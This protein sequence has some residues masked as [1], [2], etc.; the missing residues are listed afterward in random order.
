V[1]AAGGS[2]VVEMNYTGTQ[3][4]GSRSIRVDVDPNNFIAEG[5][6][7]DN[8]ATLTLVINAPA[9][10]NLV[11]LASN[12]TFSPL[13]VS[14]NGTV[15]IHA[16]ILN[17]GAR[18]AKDV[19]VQFMDVSG[20]SQKPIGAPQSLPRIG[21]GDAATAQMS[22]TPPTPGDYTLQVVADPNN[23]IVESNEMDN[24]ASKTLTA[25]ASVA[26]NLVA[27]GS[28]L[29]FVPSAPQDGNL[30]TIHATAINNGTAA[31]TDVVVRVEDVTDPAAPVLIG[32][33]RLIDTLAPGEKATVQ[34]IYDTTGKAGE[35]TIRLTLDPIDQIAESD[36]TDNQAETTLTIA[37][38]P[39]PNLVVTADHV[40][41]TPMAPSDGQVV[42]ITVTVLNQGQL[43]ANRVEVRVLDVTGNMTVPVGTL[44]VING[45]TAGGA[46]IVQ[47][48]YDTTGK[49]GD[50]TIRV[51]VDPSNLVPETS[52]TDN[53]VD[54]P[55]TVAPP[56]TN[57]GVL[58][59]LTITNTDVTIS[60]TMPSAGDVVTLTIHVHNDGAADASSVMVRVMDVTE[61]PVQVGDDVTIPAIV[62][63]SSMTATILY[64]TTGKSGSRMLT[65]SADPNNTITE[66]NENDN[67]ATTTIPL[68]SGGTASLPP[69]QSQ[70]GSLR[71]G[72][73]DPHQPPSTDV[74]IQVATGLDPRK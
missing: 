16:I 18:E 37:P 23:F 63:G 39:S 58:P 59:N 6:E 15:N 69:A 3:K 17:Q 66:S 68:G 43:N 46:G 61:T 62:A 36:E 31:A 25:G 65:I 20:G 64:D 56:S 45:I 67:T 40:R 54:V 29:K 12:I 22:F 19:V 30:V 34:V 57:P 60:P 28:N 24:R 70:L 10:P 55:L 33:Q 49:E 74:S 32:K 42:T 48:A 44:Q 27:L 26:P 5:R 21:P 73:V 9:Q 47:V 4:P 14:A 51:V 50:H 38:P 8:T 1:I 11:V 7:S 13:A 52:E 71:A 35:R 72:G 53:Q 2:A 41:F